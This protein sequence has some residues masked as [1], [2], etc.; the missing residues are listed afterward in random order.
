MEAQRY[1]IGPE[2][3][4][5]ES[6]GSS[7]CSALESSAKSTYEAAR[8]WKAC[9]GAAQNP[10]NCYKLHR[11]APASAGGAAHKPDAR[12]GALDAPLL[13]KTRGGPFSWGCAVLLGCAGR[14]SCAHARMHGLRR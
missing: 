9:R 5:A 1:V 13:R 12:M 11:R 2:C 7:G 8:C 10:A 4:P 14:L 6:P 3:T